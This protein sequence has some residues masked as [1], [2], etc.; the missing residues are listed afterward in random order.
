MSYA[1]LM[2]QLDLDRRNDSRLK[3]AGDLAERFNARVIGIAAQAEIMPMYFADGYSASFLVEQNLADIKQRLQQAEERFRAALTARA[4]HIEWRSAIEQPALYIADQ[5]RAADL[6]ILGHTAAEDK[7]DAGTEFDPSDLIGRAGRPLL[8]VPREVDVM[9]AER[10]LIGWKD[11]PEA[12]RAVFDALPLLRLCQ[13]ALVAEI[14]ED[15]D[16]AEAQRRVED[17]VA[18][19]ACHGVKAVGKVEPAQGHLTAQLDALAIQE[20]ADLL[21]TG[22]YGH[23]KLREWILGG[24]TRD[25]LKQPSRCHL[26]AH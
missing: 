18:W 23:S 5:C 14:D 13:R 15:N 7:L 10:I 2:V 25:F 19:L 3:I 1:T 17:V 8:L 12:R 26:L 16:P 21:I 4:K 9:K 6:I 22:A 20:G 24:A 11:T